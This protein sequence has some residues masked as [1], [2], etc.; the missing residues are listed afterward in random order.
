MTSNLRPDVIPE[1]HKVEQEVNSL[2]E[3][4]EQT[5]EYSGYARP[6]KEGIPQY[7][8]FPNR[9]TDYLDLE[10]KANEVKTKYE[11]AQ[12]R[13]KLLMEFPALNDPQH[14]RLAKEHI[15]YPGTVRDNRVQ[16]TFENMKTVFRIA[17]IRASFT[18]QLQ[19]YI[20]V[21]VSFENTCSSVNSMVETMISTG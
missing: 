8:L 9:Y 11:K 7:E 19:K 21:R 20:D 2:W 16:T 6:N 12:L 1:T 14:D 10:K 5:L 4:I 3:V 18:E 15:Y 13:D 17:K